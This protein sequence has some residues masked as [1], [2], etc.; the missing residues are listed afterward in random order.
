MLVLRDEVLPVAETAFD[1]A[2]KIYQLGKLDLLG[3]LDTQRTYFDVR[4]QFIETLT[5]YQL[6]VINIERLIGGGLESFQ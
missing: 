1:S 3:L 2:T 5:A 4:Q 6:M